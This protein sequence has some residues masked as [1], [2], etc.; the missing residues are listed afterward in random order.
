MNPVIEIVVLA[1][2]TLLSAPIPAHAQAADE[3]SC[4]QFL[5]SPREVKGKK[6][7]PT[8][9]L[10][11]E[12]DLSIDGRTYKRVDIGLNG[13]VEGYVAKTGE[14]H[15]YLTNAPDLVFPQSGN[16]G[17][18]LFAVAAY[19]RDKGAAMTIVYPA[20]RAAWNQKMYVTA[21][22]RGTSFKQGSLKPWN[23]NLDRSNPLSDL[24]KYDRLMIAKGYV[25]VKTHRT[26][27]EGLGEIKA[28]LEDG[29][30]VDFV[31]FNDTARYI[32]DFGDVAKKLAA[33]RLGQA[34]RLSYI[35]G[36][37]AGARIG[38][39]INYTPGL[40]LGRDGKPYF[41]GVLAD[42][43]A[44]GTWLPI[45]MKD[46]KDVLFA[47]EAEKAAFVPQLDISH[48]MYNNIWD[49]KMPSYMSLSYLANK[50]RNAKM[51]RDKGLAPAKER[52]Y[53]V[54]GIS[55]SGGEGYPDGRR[56]AI[57]ILDLSRAMD[58]V[59]DLLDAW[60]DKG[61]EP[62]P[63]HSDW[64]ELGA[65]PALAFPEIACPLGIYY[66]TEPASGTTSFAAFT[67]EGLEPL[68]GKKVFVDMNRNGVWDYRETPA[69][70]WRRLGLLQKG[71]DLT[72]D[73]YVSC[74][75]SA[76]EQL[77]KEGFFSDKTAADYVEHAKKVELRPKSTTSQ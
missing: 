17:P 14:Y 45:V 1:I 53:E 59:I 64:A 57:E 61:V 52:M 55:H 7:G 43:A 10:M 32:M 15:E 3:A 26:S 22:G 20:D 5:L 18:I 65:Q 67:G 35:Y 25:L 48:Q 70:A 58:K 6:V 76:A 54:R 49:H 38:R 30:V 46:G 28:T 12:S 2:V 74:V 42:D 50:R 36:H 63:T 4:D 77:R 40:N 29:T 37:S 60:V 69:E 56:G 62:P 27:A 31:A 19:E 75:Q 41:N 9:C 11:Q 47:T 13:S 71:E 72:R 51:L 33:A 34:P 39:G 16:P 23:R 66:P 21:H 73:K 68:D 8:S 44:A 24:S